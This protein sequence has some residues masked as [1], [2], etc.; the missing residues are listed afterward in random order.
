MKPFLPLAALLL[1]ASPA[2]S[3]S[4]CRG[5]TQKGELIE[6]ELVSVTANDE[7]LTDVSAYGNY[8]VAI[9]GTV[10]TQPA[11][12]VLNYVQFHASRVELDGTGREQRVDLY[13]FYP[14]F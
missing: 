2:G 7:P 9:E 11:D 12:G 5:P 8:E 10:H 14:N 13:E 3:T 1:L 6:L 4:P